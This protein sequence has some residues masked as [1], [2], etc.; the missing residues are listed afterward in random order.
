MTTV[1][2]TLSPISD[3]AAI[4]EYIE[5]DSAR[6]ALRVVDRLTKR[7]KQ[8]V[9]FPMSGQMVPEYQREDVREIIEYSYRVI[10]YLVENQIFIIAVIHSAKPL[11]DTPPINAG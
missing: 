11:Q 9:E 4:Y 6:Y 5:S 2:W 1:D 3:L 8:L 10:Y 7:T